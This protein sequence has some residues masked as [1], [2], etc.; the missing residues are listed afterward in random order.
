[1]SSLATLNS[2]IQ[3]SN[4]LTL[5]ELLAWHPDIARRTAQRLIATL[6]ESG[7]V[8]TQG[9]GRARRYFGTGAQTGASSP[10]NSADGFP[11]FMP[12]SADSQDILAYIDQPAALRKPVGY[13]RDFLDAYHPNQT[14]YL[15]EPLRRQLHNMGNH[16]AQP[17]GCR[18]QT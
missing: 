15:S 1:M 5:A 14:W 12:L 10:V 9:Q 4:G 6:I 18:R 8:T 17:T 16:C 13:Q 3:K 11:R 7:Q 2:S